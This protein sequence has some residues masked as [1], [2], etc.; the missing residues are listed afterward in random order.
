MPN[1]T[2][3]ATYDSIKEPLLI[4]AEYRAA[5][6]WVTR[7]LKPSPQTRCKQGTFALREAMQKENGVRTTNG[8]FAWLLIHFGFEP[9]KGHADELQSS[10]YFQATLKGKTPNTR[11]P[12]ANRKRRPIVA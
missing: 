4:E 9:V 2:P 12:S 5:K 3:N 11:K 7:H 6:Q 10:Y 1:E 8:E